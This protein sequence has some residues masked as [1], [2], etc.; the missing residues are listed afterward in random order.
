MLFLSKSFHQ[1]DTAA[2][3]RK[4]TVAVK[5]EYEGVMEENKKGRK[6]IKEDKNKPAASR[7]SAKTE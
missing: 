6:K 7:R 2:A 4:F 5:D 1:V 3:E